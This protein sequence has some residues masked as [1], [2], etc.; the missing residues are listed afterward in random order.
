MAGKLATAY[1]DIVGRIQGDILT[2]IKIIAAAEVKRERR[3]QSAAVE[4]Y[5]R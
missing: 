3:E 1:I 2:Q 4:S 5:G